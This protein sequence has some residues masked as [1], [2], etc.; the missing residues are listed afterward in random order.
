MR[1]RGGYLPGGRILNIPVPHTGQTPLSAGRPLPSSPAGRSRSSASPY[2]SHSNL[3]P[4]PSGP[5][6]SPLSVAPPSGGTGSLGNGEAASARQHNTVAL[7][8][9]NRAVLKTISFVRSV[10]ERFG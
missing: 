1:D 6:P 2:T 3:R 9:G 4:R 5:F 10:T 7:G 8:G